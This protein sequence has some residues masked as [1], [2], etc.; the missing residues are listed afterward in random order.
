[1]T[2]IRICFHRNLSPISCCVDHGDVPACKQ[3]ADCGEWV[4]WD[5]MEVYVMEEEE[6][7]DI[8]WEPRTYVIQ[9]RYSGPDE[10]VAAAFH[11]AYERL[12]P[13]YGYKTREES[14]VH[15]EA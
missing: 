14:A 7:I 15:W 10:A 2:E 11:E 5:K 12:A 13:E 9:Q 6:A 3:C 4:S 8:I 1:M